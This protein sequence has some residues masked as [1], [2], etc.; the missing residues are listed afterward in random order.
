MSNNTILS[1]FFYVL[2][3][4]KC[5]LLIFGISLDTVLIPSVKID[6]GEEFLRSG[7]Y[8]V[9]TVLSAGHALHVFIN[10]QLAGR[11]LVSYFWLKAVCES[12]SSKSQDAQNI[13]SLIFFQKSHFRASLGN[14]LFLKLLAG[15]SYGSLEFPKLTFSKGVNLR[16]G[17][18]TITLLSIAVGL[19]VCSLS[20]SLLSSFSQARFVFQ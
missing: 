19:P 9:L 17:I 2:H 16:A 4:R 3:L 8:P 20:L 18:N 13:D 10:G 14:M 6:S 15:T 7:N 11:H 1:L 12:A 5:F